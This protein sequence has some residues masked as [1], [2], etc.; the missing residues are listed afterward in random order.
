MGAVLSNFTFLLRDWKQNTLDELQHVFADNR[1][2][3][4]GTTAQQVRQLAADACSL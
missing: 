3:M 4:G 1:V 2:Y